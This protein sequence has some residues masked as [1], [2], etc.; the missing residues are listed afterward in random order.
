MT[1]QV[2]VTTS[3]H[4]YNNEDIKSNVVTLAAELKQCRDI[5]A[6]SRHRRKATMLETMSNVAT[7]AA[8]SNQCCNIDNQSRNIVRIGK[9]PDVQY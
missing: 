3:E 2:R 1:S 4:G 7:S 9:N 6:V 5:I 8:T